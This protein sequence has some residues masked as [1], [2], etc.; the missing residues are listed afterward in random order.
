MRVAQAGLPVG[1][2]FVCGAARQ[3]G[4]ARLEH[5]ENLGLEPLMGFPGQKHD[6]RVA[7]SVS[8]EEHAPCK[9]HR[10][11]KVYRSPH[12][13]FWTGDFPLVCG[14]NF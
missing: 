10:R 9:P 5:S 2:G 1:T 4:P 11:E 12:T 6:S 14:G 8:G 13:S 3:R 7:V